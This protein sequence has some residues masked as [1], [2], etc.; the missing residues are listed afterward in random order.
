VSFSNFI[1]FQNF[2]AH[3]LTSYSALDKINI[4]TREMLMADESRLPD[5]TLAIEVLAYIT[6]RNGRQGA[7]I[8]VEKP[9]FDVSSPNLPG[10]E[11]D[12]TLEILVLEDR[13]TNQGPTEG[14]QLAADQIA[15]TI[16]DALHWQQFEGFGQMFCDRA[17]MTE[18]KEFQPLSA[19]RLRFRLR[20][21]RGQTTKVEQPTISEAA[22]EITLACATSGAQIYFTTDG[23]FPGSSNAA[24]QLYSAPFTV[25]AGTVINAAA[26][27]DGLTPSHMIQ[28]TVT[29]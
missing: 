21:P 25:T 3:Y 27:K 7:G 10:P 28:A 18:A 9:G 23:T 29:A 5:D 11:G 14:T 26:F 8:I 2:V 12:I 16:M 6:P 4:V 1:K 15:Q 19:Y 22:L 20:M 24:A 13:L 17:A